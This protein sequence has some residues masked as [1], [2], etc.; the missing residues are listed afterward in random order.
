MLWD[1]VKRM[2]TRLLLL[3][4]DQFMFNLNW[5]HK[6]WTDV[7]YWPMNILIIN[8]VI[9][10]SN[11][12]SNEQPSQINNQAEEWILG[13]NNGWN[14]P[15]RTETT[16]QFQLD[17]E[18]GQL[19]CLFMVVFVSVICH[20]DRQSDWE[21]DRQTDRRMCIVRTTR[22]DPGKICATIGHFMGSCSMMCV[23][24]KGAH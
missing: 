11:D 23:V 2:D 16:H 8:Q 1:S 12:G 10:Y 3:H 24:W 18:F 21:T 22:T 7:R 20:I 19:K 4:F 17:T 13:W 9:A 15:Q 6:Q 14:L 5:I